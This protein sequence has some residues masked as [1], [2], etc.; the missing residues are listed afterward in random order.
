M[1][2][3]TGTP[4]SARR[5]AREASAPEASAIRNVVLDIGG[6][7][8][9]WNPER[10]AAS[11]FEDPDVQ[12]NVLETVFLHEDW[13]ELDLGELGEA[14]AVTI[15]SRRSGRSEDEMWAL[16]RAAHESLDLLP[17]ALALLDW[18]AARGLRLF[19]LSNMH[20][21][22]LA[23]LKKRYGFWTKFEG[24]V[25]SGD[26]R[27]AKPHPEIFRYL[28]REYA[29]RAGE[30]VLIDDAPANVEGARAVGMQAIRFTS[31][32]DCR[33]QIERLLGD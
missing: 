12:R 14:E 25:I 2:G 13:R 8:V 5:P 17:G 16:F 6:V 15:F 7:L 24:V 3:A 31:A 4:P 28:L 23:Y 20:P 33:G 32:E 19:C 29:L 27:L 26:V 11:V 1:S 18:L 30:T 9:E 10:I 21:A 22:T